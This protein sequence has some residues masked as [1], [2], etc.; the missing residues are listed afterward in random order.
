M[1]NGIFVGLIVVALCACAVAVQPSQISPG[2]IL[3]TAAGDPAYRVAGDPNEP[4][5]VAAHLSADWEYVSVTMT[6]QV[7]NP[8]MQSGS[9]T[10]GPQW[11][12]GV[13]SVV[14][15]LD[16]E[17]LLGWSMSPTS[18]QAYDQNGQ[19]V[20]SSDSGD[21][22]GRFYH[23]PTSWT[24]SAL[25]DRFHLSFPVDP[26][27]AYPEMF[28]R[29]DWT[30]GLL[31]VEET[32]TVDVPFETSDA[33][34]ELTPGFKV[35]VVEATASEGKYKYRLDVE[36][37][38]TKVDNLMSGSLHVW[39]DEVLPPAAALSMAVL[40]ADGKAVMEVSGGNGGETR[41]MHAGGSATLKTG[42][43]TGSGSCS[44][45]G[46]AKTIRFTLGFNLYE[47]EA[48]FTLED[49]PVPEF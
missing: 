18:A 11:S 12:L 24:L 26:N 3:I 37:D 31:L 9:Q 2:D 43:L 32:K 1:R 45:C 30:L 46:D 8:A 15:T 14:N 34:F 16:K 7:Y 21:P 33:W 22:I 42:Q 39:S 29:I 35:M 17:G 27:A 13:S 19:V 41:G 49:V 25:Q 48:T 47:Q 36:Y 23:Q 10:E 20:F 44:A 5:D 38:P 28:S 4:W 6:S 40:N